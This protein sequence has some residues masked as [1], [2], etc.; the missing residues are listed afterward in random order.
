[1]STEHFGTHTKQQTQS[2]Q[3]KEETGHDF[4]GHIAPYGAKVSWYGASLGG[5]LC[6]TSK[7]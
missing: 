2:M 6:N 5:P 7:T 3:V 1:M 4:D